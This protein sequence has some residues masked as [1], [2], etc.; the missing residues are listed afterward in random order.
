[1]G[2]QQLNRRNKMTEEKY[3]SKLQEKFGGEHFT[4]IHRGENSSDSS[5]FKCLDCGRRITIQNGELFRKKRKYICAKCHYKRRDTERNEQIIRKRLEGKTENIRF[6]ME[7]RKGIRHNKVSFICSKCGKTNEKEVANFLRQKFDCSFCEGMKESKDTDIFLQE[8]NE[9]FG[10]RFSLVSGYVDAK[11][12]VTIRCNSCGFIRQVKPPAFLISGF[13]PRCGDKK[14]TGEKIIATFLQKEEIWYEE[15]KYFSDWDIGLHYFDFYIPKYNCIIEYHGIQHYQY[16][17]FFH[18]SEEDFQ[19]RVEK[20]KI[21]KEAA[22]EHNL[23]YISIKY[24]LKE[25]LPVILEKLFNSTTIPEGSR[26]KCF[27]IETIQDI[28]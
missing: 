5:I 4:V 16:N 26:G 14:S 2:N 24:T 13:C 7:N 19:Y 10:N 3:Y 6:F 21:K 23:N 27:E 22:L 20:D 12:N 28:G 17:E 18:K 25:N 9:K 8:M 11:T 15:Q 1:M